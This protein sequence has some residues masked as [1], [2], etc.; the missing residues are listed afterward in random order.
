MEIL[1]KLNEI[2]H[3]KHLEQ[4]LTYVGCLHFMPQRKGKTRKDWKL[5]DNTGFEKNVFII[6]VQNSRSSVCLKSRDMGLTS[7]SATR[8]L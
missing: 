2:A 3:L 1:C 6:S 4:W 7:N 5:E 8:Q